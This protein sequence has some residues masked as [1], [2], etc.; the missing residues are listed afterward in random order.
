MPM[1][2]LAAADMRIVRDVAHTITES[3]STDQVSWNVAALQPLAQLVGAEVVAHHVLTLTAAGWTADVVPWPVDSQLDLDP[4]IL[5]D[6][7]LVRHYATHP[8]D[9]QTLR[10][11][12]FLTLREVRRTA[13]FGNVLKPLGTPWLMAVPVM[14][15]GSSGDGFGL[16]RSGRDFTVREQS[17]GDAL[18]A[19]LAGLR[20][21]QQQQQRQDRAR[22]AA[23]QLSTREHDVVCLLQGGLTAAAIGRRLAISERTVHKHLEHIY[24]KLGTTDRLS[25]I[26]AFEDGP[27]R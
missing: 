13:L 7:P 27:N 23:S 21:R 10:L 17:L 6:H 24:R 22:A 18:Y 2:A 9:C 12:Q 11:S 3:T 4:S 5:D 14:F 16:T 19:L 25:T 26:R 1:N 20:H 15:T 8:D